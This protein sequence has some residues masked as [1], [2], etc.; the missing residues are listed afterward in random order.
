MKRRTML[1]SKID[2]ATVTVG[3][4]GA[5]DAITIDA[6]LLDAADV[7]DYEQVAV[8]DVGTGARFDTY[9]RAGARGSGVVRVD[10]AAARLI[11]QSGPIV[12]HSF[13]VHMALELD[14]YAPRVVS[15]DAR[16]QV[17]AVDDG[18]R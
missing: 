16:N 11:R 18:R 2:R 15:V 12:V 9:A 1:K 7:L 13:A 17:V 4:S 3:D 6:N 5:A 10:G 14:G 8:V